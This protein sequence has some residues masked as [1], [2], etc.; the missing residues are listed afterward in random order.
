MKKGFYFNIIC[1][2]E[3]GKQPKCLTIRNLSQ[4]NVYSML[5]NEESKTKLYE[6]FFCDEKHIFICVYMG[7]YIYTN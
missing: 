5:L 7:I 2:R 4:V 6:P 3:N 1:N